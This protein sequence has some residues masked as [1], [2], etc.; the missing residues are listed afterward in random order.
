MS[1]DYYKVLQ[2]DK[3]A[4]ADDIK[5]SYRKLAVKLHPDTNPDKANAD[6]QFKNLS[7]AYD[8]L[9]DPDKRAAY[10]R[11]GHNAFKSGGA[12]RHATAPDMSDFMG[13]FFNEANIFS[14]FFGRHRQPSNK[15]AD[16]H[17][18]TQITLQEAFDGCER[19]IEYNHLKSCEPC[20]AT[21]SSK[22]QGPVPCKTCGGSGSRMRN[23]RGIVERTTCN[24][25]NG[26]GTVVEHKCKQCNGHGNFSG[27]NSIK[28]AIPPGISTDMKVR[29]QH[30]G[31]AGVRGG[32]HGDLYIS[33]GISMP[34]NVTRNGNDLQH[35]ISVTYPTAV[36]G[37]SALIEIFKDEK[38]NC[39]IP[40]GTVS[41]TEL[42]VRGRGMRILNTT[43]RGD[44]ILKVNI[45]V[46]RN[47]TNDEKDLLLKLQE[48]YD[49]K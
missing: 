18:S 1:L 24:I 44:V 41:G 23:N 3:N 26:Y 45:T 34:E 27:K 33:V 39:T 30:Q 46:P 47:I 32:Q 21:G 13:S 42:R 19:V 4:S 11:Y 28:I 5:K 20:R 12:T 10:D 35:E 6:E 36:L 14:S 17:L 15:G 8:V 9:S 43:H 49:K 25:C 48:F 40:Q 7:E 22:G 37:G 38:L 2:V 16:I 31:N 29:S